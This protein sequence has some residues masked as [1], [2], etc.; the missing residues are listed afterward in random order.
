MVGARG[1]EPLT[2]TM[3][4]RRSKYKQRFDKPNEIGMPFRLPH[5]FRTCWRRKHV[6]L[7]RLGGH[8]QMFI[9]AGGVAGF[10]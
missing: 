7:Q 10:P 9:D 3:S 4:R 8:F 2:P 6:G 5:A 1:I